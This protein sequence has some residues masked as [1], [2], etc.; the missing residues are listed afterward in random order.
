MKR[1]TLVRTLTFKLLGK[2]RHATCLAGHA[3]LFERSPVDPGLFIVW[4]GKHY[5]RVDAI[6]LLLTVAA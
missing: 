5:A 1:G 4:H 3:V 2:E 6:D